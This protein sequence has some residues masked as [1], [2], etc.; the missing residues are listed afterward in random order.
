MEK[1]QLLLG[2]IIDTIGLDGTVK[3]FS[4]TNNQDIRYK[5]GNKVLIQIN[6]DLKEM[7]IEKFRAKGQFDCLKFE[8]ISTIEQAEAL[9]GASIKIYKDINDLKE[10]YF[11][12]SDLEGCVIQD[13]DGKSYGKVYRIEEYPANLNLRIKRDN[14]KEFLLPFIK[15]FIVKVD[16]ENKVILINYMEGL[17]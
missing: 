7:V 16:I 3:V 1:E 5:K 12:Y 10:G 17:L 8:G 11:Y 9:K 2:N 15:E 13:K 4:T 6:D 14:G